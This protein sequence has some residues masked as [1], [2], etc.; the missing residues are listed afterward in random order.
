MKR[1]EVLKYMRSQMV[2]GNDIIMA[3]LG[4]GGA[5]L[6]FADRFGT[7]NLL[8]ELDD[9]TYDGI[10]EPAA[11]IRDYKYYNEDCVVVQFA[12]GDYY[13]QILIEP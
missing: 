4:N 8:K 9:Y 1:K 5:G 2:Q 11:Y 12:E 10:V 7:W 3:T 6:T 13:I